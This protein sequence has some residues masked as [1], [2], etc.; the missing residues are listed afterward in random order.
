VRVDQILE[1]RAQ[2]DGDKTAVVCGEDRRTYREIEEQSKLFAR[3]LLNAGLRPGDRAAICLDDPIETIV[4]LFGVLKVGG[5]FVIIAAHTP[6]EQRQ[7]IL[8]DSGASVLIS[9][10]GAPSLRRTRSADRAD[11]NLAALVYT[12]GSTGE[13]KG[14]M[15]THGNLM[16]AAVSIC[17]YLDLTSSD[18]ILNVL[19]LAFTYG[20]GQ[21]TTAFHA[22]ATLV[23]ERSFA[24][25]QAVIRTMLRERVTGFPLVPTIATLLL[26]QDLRKHRFPHLRYITNAAAALS[27]SKIERLRQRFPETA[28]Y[29]MYGLTE[30]QRVSYLPPDQID[31]RPDSVGVAIP[32][33]EVYIVDE[34]GGRAAAG[35][36]GELVVKGPHVMAG[37]W[38]RADATARMLRPD[39]TGAT[40][41]HTGDLF[42]MDRDGFL[43]FVERK[44]DMIKTRGEKVAPRQVEEVIARLDGVAEVAV[45]GVPDGLL[46][47]AIA[48]VV[49]PA[50]GAI[51]SSE[52]VK[53]HCLEHLGAI[54]VP[55][56]VHIRDVL[57]TTATGKISRHALQAADAHAGRA[58][59]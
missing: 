40:V 57:P 16:A 58:S 36:I 7:R 47:E 42:R 15:L 11:A 21:V 31:T 53:R 29:S 56:I 37:Y 20:L 26:Q 25:P 27:L 19:P 12:S 48:A 55:K 5:V 18:V 9:R 13:P 43:Y 51:L 45:Y 10:D 23:L 41:L 1:R 38:N 50:P 14:V 34:R 6:F 35:T 3:V 17:R 49:T 54:M 22:G 2:V 30:C 44:D 52:R 32:G 33:T 59:A 28:I 46:G 39:P 4:S 8:A 24:F